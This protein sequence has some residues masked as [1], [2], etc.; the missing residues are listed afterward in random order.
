MA[1]RFDGFKYRDCQW[2]GGSGCLACEGEA[3]KAYK[4]AFPDGPVPLA[5]FD[6]STPE[7]AAS[8]RQA[9]G[10]EAITKAFSN[11]GGGIAEII[12]NIEKVKS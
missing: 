12:A 1:A 2:C 11:G 9:I 7:G 6:I 10:A 4:R 3:D 5:T 8:A